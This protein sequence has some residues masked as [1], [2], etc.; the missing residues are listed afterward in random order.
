MKCE[1]SGGVV[2]GMKP[3]II[4][5]NVNISLSIAQSMTNKHKSAS[6]TM[7]HYI[8]YLL[9]VSEIDCNKKY[10]FRNRLEYLLEI[11]IEIEID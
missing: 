5:R 6:P 10:V 11:E 2:A 8:A 7:R 4:C 3:V 9:F 1:Y